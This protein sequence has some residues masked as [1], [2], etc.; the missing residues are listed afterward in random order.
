VGR[1]GKWELFQG[2]IFTEAVESRRIGSANNN[3]DRKPL[4]SLIIKELCLY[5]VKI[6]AWRNFQGSK[7]GIEEY[8]TFKVRKN[9][10]CLLKLNSTPR[11]VLISWISINTAFPQLHNL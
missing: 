1:H 9:S 11:K 5:L 2:H 10:F 3:D 6:K 7:C 4:H 8:Y